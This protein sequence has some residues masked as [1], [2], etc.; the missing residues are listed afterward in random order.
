VTTHDPFDEGDDLEARIG[1][2]WCAVLGMSV[3]ADDDFFDLGG[4]SVQATMIVNRLQE[5]V[6]GVLHAAV[7]FEAGTV[8][9]LAEMCRAQQEA[10]EVEEA[11]TD[12]AIERGFAHLAARNN[13]PSTGVDLGAG[14][15]GRAI[16]VLAPPRSHPSV[17]MTARTNPS[18]RKAARSTRRSRRSARVSKPSRYSSGGLNRAG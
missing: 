2:I 15:N 16:F 6:A 3:G 11:L 18:A 14:R 9:R 12:A 4:T 1:R 5:H 13:N 8:R 7:V 17:A 10:V